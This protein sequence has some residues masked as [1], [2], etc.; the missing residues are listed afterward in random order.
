[1]PDAPG[2]T[3][4]PTDHQRNTSSLNKNDKDDSDEWEYEYSTTETEVS[5]PIPPNNNAL[6]KT[7]PIT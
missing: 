4:I 1:M 2:E 5:N 3:A 7:R 6:T